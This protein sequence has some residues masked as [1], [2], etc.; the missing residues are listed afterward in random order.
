MPSTDPHSVCTPNHEKTLETCKL[1]N[2][3]E[4]LHKNWW[5]WASSTTFLFFL[6]F[7]FFEENSG[8]WTSFL[9]ELSGSLSV[10]PL[11]PL[12]RVF[13]PRWGEVAS[14]GARLFGL[15][16]LVWGFALFGGVWNIRGAQC[17][18]PPYPWPY[19][20]FISYRIFEWTFIRYIDWF[21]LPVRS[22]WAEV[23]WGPESPKFWGIFILLRAFIWP[24]EKEVSI[25]FS[26]APQEWRWVNI[27]F[28][29]RPHL[30]SGKLLSLFFSGGDMLFLSL[31]LPIPSWSDPTGPFR[32]RSRGFCWRGGLALAPPWGMEPWHRHWSVCVCIL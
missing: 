1:E 6:F 28:F 8:M 11:P 14:F 5:R 20:R 24:S 15:I 9:P 32:G 22:R 19:L 25:L 18:I 21:K 26:T 31:S 16:F 7:S 10:G 13:I 30:R 29:G 12:L 17:I 23:Y 2:T 4:S 27:L 3:W